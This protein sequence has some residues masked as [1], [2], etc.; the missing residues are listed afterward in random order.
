MLLTPVKKRAVAERNDRPIASRTG[1]VA[2]RRNPLA[3]LGVSV[4][5]R[6]DGGVTGLNSCD[7][8]AIMGPTIAGCKGRFLSSDKRHQYNPPRSGIDARGG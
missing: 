2:Q 6:S 4:G 3:G 5:D 7:H 1:F 8:R